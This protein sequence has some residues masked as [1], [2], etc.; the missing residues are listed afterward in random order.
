MIQM[1]LLCFMMPSKS[2]LGSIPCHQIML[3]LY[4]ISQFFGK[5]IITKQHVS[6]WIYKEDIIW[7]HVIY[8][9]ADII[10]QT[11]V[12]PWL[13]EASTPG[14]T[15][16]LNLPSN[17]WMVNLPPSNTVMAPQKLNGPRTRRTT[18]LT[19]QGSNT[20]GWGYPH[21]SKHFD[22]FV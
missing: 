20:N 9:R 2:E 14:E 11:S 6:W 17:A 4:I 12:I 16:Q 8:Y 21:D 13:I 1:F 18:N 5:Q 15:C 3:Y 22:L 19:K 10:Q 7:I